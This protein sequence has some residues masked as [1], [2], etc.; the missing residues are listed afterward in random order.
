MKMWKKIFQTG[1]LSGNSIIL[2]L[3]LFVANVLNY[4]FHL[5]IGRAVTVSEY[6]QIESLI[7]LTNIIS[8]PAATLAMIVTKYGARYRATKDIA[9]NAFFV[10]WIKKK[11]FFSGV[12]VL[13]ACLLV[14]PY[15]ARFLRIDNQLA[16]ILIW[17]TLF[18]S[19]FATVN[20]GTLSGWQKFREVGFL[21]VA[22]SLFKLIFGVIFV[23]FGFSVSGAIGGI[24]FGTVC[25]YA[26]SEF[27]LSFLRRAVADGRGESCHVRFH[28]KV[29]SF[30][31]PFFVGNLAISIFGNIDMVFAKRILDPAEAGQYG[32][33]TVVA[34]I[35]FF[36]TSIVAGVL[37]SM[38]SERHHEKKDTKKIFQNAA[39]IVFGISFLSVAGY[40]VFPEFLLGML[41]GEK[42]V[43]VADYLGWFAI[44][45]V[46]L[47]FLY[48]I[49][50][51][52][53][54]IHKIR[55]V[56]R[57][58]GLSFLFS[59][60]IIFFARDLC[61][62]LGMTIVAQ[63]IGLFFGIYFLKKM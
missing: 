55:I 23:Q 30:L 25:A 26:V 60:G 45:A 15:A 46:L 56:Y 39:Y 3:G 49:F 43:D 44:S 31:I 62:I 32:A 14:T 2:F 7:A 58:L 59:G 52:L 24:A 38:A 22:G 34:K 10:A 54:A 42:Y 48:L 5:V 21:G 63:A 53:L 61:D 40:F 9:E 28:K 27:F 36:A 11:I 13:I 18:V 47:S 33:L 37:F 29:Q 35:I 50:Q 51:Y 16:L 6:G 17:M 57:L 41:F 8:V 1:T 4:V 20:S 19:F 12:I